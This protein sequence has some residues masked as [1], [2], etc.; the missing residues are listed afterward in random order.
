MATKK[1]PTQRTETGYEIPVP[2]HRER[3]KAPLRPWRSH[4]PRHGV[5]TAREKKK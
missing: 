3:S 2:T 5:V 4:K 1:Q